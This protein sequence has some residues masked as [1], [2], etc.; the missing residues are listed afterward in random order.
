MKR[1]QGLDRP[2]LRFMVWLAAFGL[3]AA[4]WAASAGQELKP[5]PRYVFGL[6]SS[7]VFRW[8][9]KGAGTPFLDC[10]Y[11]MDSGDTLGIQMAV[12]PVGIRPLL[13]P[14]LP[15]T[16]IKWLG[17]AIGLQTPESPCNWTEDERRLFAMSPGQ[18]PWWL[19]WCGGDLWQQGRFTAIRRATKATKME[20]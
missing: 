10:I 11:G 2:V 4:I 5:Q 9:H 6:H 8:M 18:E 7:V 15:T 19:R 14:T 20:G 3:L 16:E 13:C 17:V 1:G 12:D